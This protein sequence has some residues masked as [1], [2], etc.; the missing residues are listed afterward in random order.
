MIDNVLRTIL[1]HYYEVI[2]LFILQKILRI[3]VIHRP[4]DPIANVKIIVA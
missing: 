4:V 2:L 1:R 3:H